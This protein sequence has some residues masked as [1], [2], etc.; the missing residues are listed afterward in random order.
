MESDSFLR[1][2]WKRKM[3]EEKGE[4]QED[5]DIGLYL[6][7]QEDAKKHPELTP[8]VLELEAAIGKYASS[9]VRY[10]AAKISTDMEE[11]ESA[12]QNRR[13]VHNSLIDVMNHLSREY[14][15]VGIDNNWRGAI[16][17]ESREEL[18]DWAL[19]VARKVLNHE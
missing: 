16:I 6:R 14:R 1:D 9:V 19:T 2:S 10:S 15:A 12:D 5:K 8:I 3:E 11:I 13:L 4:T 18:G 7:F 17:G